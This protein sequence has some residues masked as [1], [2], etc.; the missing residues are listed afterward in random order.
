[1][2]SRKRLI[3]LRRENLLLEL[4]VNGKAASVLCFMNL[5]LF[6]PYINSWKDAPPNPTSVDPIQ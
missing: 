6:H 5:A 4:L 1:M 2:L 3:L